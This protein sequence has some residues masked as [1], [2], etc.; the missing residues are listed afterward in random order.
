[1]INA[2]NVYDRYN[3]F[4][5]ELDGLEIESTINKSSNG[6]SLELIRHNVYILNISGLTT[7]EIFFMLNA[8]WQFTKEVLD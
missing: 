3:W 1:M 8:L 7:R 6:W 4:V 2:K 5:S